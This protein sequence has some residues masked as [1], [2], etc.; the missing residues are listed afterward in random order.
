MEHSSWKESW[1]SHLG[2]PPPVQEAF[3]QPPEKFYIASTWPSFAF[4]D[5]SIV[6]LGSISQGAAS[7][8]SIALPFDKLLRYM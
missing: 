5:S 7:D 2:Q 4:E 6:F 1:G 8:K 3:L